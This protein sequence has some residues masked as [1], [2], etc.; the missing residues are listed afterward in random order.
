MTCWQSK[1][2]INAFLG[3]LLKLTAGYHGKETIQ[4]KTATPFGQQSCFFILIW[5]QSTLH[6]RYID[7][8]YRP[9]YIHSL[10]YL[11]SLTAVIVIEAL[12]P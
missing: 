8:N 4:K 9:K 7:L 10:S 2:G 11:A 5:S 1:H 3:G 12:S 6:T